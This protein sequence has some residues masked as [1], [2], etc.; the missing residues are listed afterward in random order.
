ME[1][2]FNEKACDGFM[3][4]FP[5]LPRDLEAFAEKVVPILQER[6][7]FRKDYTGSTL[8]EHLGLQIPENQFAKSKVASS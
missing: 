5:L 8:R 2:W 7:L 6:G 3:L 1:R 4:Q